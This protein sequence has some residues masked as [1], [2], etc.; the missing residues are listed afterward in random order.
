MRLI[1]LDSDSDYLLDGRYAIHGRDSVPST[2]QSMTATSNTETS[3]TVKIP[4]FD[5][6]TERLPSAQ[7][8]QTCEYWD[9]ESNF[10]AL[11]RPSALRSCPR[12]CYS[13]PGVW[14]FNG[15]W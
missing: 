9:S 11:C 12:S 2:Q 13:E 8:R 6:T 7:P 1:D 4:V 14:R 15:L 10:C 5:G 3:D